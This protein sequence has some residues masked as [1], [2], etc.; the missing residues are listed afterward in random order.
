[1]KLSKLL[2]NGGG[3]S[4][5]RLAGLQPGALQ[6]SSNQASYGPPIL[7]TGVNIDSG[8]FVQIAN[9]NAPAGTAIVLQ[10]ARL[11]GLVAGNNVLYVEIEVDGVK[12]LAGSAPI[13]DNVFLFGSY[14]GGGGTGASTY[15]FKSPT[16]A[17]EILA[18]SNVKIRVKHAGSTNVTVFVHYILVE[19]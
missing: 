9:I 2:G 3:G 4:G 15:G 1:M 6:I 13:A 18:F 11:T 7:N 16:L 14:G 17:S 12:V 10:A 8:S 19:A 5:V